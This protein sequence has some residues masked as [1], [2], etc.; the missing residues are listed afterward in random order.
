MRST[1]RILTGLILSGMFCGAAMAAPAPTDTKAP[2]TVTRSSA[3]T[4]ADCQRLGGEV[5]A[6]ID[7]RKD[8][9]NI[10]QARSVFQFGIMECMEGSDEVANR[11]YLEAKNLLGSESPTSSIRL[12]GVK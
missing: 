5:S 12:P 3:P 10:A 9:P 6:L 11:H 2:A 7:Q 1:A 8:S 4:Q